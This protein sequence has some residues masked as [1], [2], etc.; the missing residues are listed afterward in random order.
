MEAMCQPRRFWGLWL[1]L[2]ISK[3][4]LETVSE[5]VYQPGGFRSS[6]CLKESKKFIKCRSDCVSLSVI[7]DCFL[8]LGFG[9]LLYHLGVVSIASVTVKQ[10]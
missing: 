1:K 9:D 8:S 3:E 5:A 6:K 7:S 4:V 10:K 2:C